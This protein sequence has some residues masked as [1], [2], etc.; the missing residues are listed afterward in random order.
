M[1]LNY[2][3][4]ALINRN[5]MIAIAR[6]FKLFVSRSTIHRWA[7]EPE[8]P[9]AVGVDGQSLLYTRSEFIDFLKQRVREIQAE[10]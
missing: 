6:E 10:H 4:G 3:R 7:N 5:Q 9:L 2:E 8:F 1:K